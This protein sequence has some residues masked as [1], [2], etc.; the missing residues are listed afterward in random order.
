VTSNDKEP[1]IKYLGVYFDENLN[2]KVY[3]IYISNQASSALYSLRTVRNILL[4]KSLKDLHYSLFHCHL[5]YAIELWSSTTPSVLK[6]QI[7]KQNVAIQI[8][9][10]RK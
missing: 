3:A 7:T 6:P 10:D 5:I 2:F 1:A 9:A 8:I 4:P